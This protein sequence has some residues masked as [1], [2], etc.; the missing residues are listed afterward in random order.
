[1]KNKILALALAA[2]A[3]ALP[4]LS[5][6]ADSGNTANNGFFI[7]GNLGRS[8]LSSG[9][10]NDNDTGYAAN[11]G[12]RWA[13][14]PNFLFGVEGGYTKLGSFDPKSTYNGVGLDRA[15]VKGW[16]LGVNGH[17]NLSP[18]WYVSARGGYFRGDA[19]GDQIVG[20]STLTDGSTLYAVN[21][22]DDTSNK[23]YAGAGFGYDFSNNVSVGLNYDYYKTDKNGLKLDPSLVSVSAEYRF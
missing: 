6:A 16:N 23:Y 11:V 21:H 9:A 13:L 20:S 15:E 10:Y 4:V 3:I 12:Y 18:N 17:L 14:A 19:R 2:S 7:N 8:D 5:Q 22:V 1:M